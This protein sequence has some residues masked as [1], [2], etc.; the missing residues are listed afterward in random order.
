MKFYQVEHKIKILHFLSNWLNSNCG[1]IV[2]EV[3][4]IPDVEKTI[5]ENVKTIIKRI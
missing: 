5:V 4:I 3:R 1:I 2:L